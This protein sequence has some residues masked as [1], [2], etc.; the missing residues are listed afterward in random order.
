MS[1][2]YLAREVKFD[3]I[4]TMDN[5]LYGLLKEVFKDRTVV[6][7]TNQDELEGVYEHIIDLEEKPFEKEVI[8]CNTIDYGDIIDLELFSPA[9]SIYREGFSISSDSMVEYDV[10]KDVSGLN[11]CTITRPELL[12]KLNGSSEQVVTLCTTTSSRVVITNE[13][14]L[15]NDLYNTYSLSEESVA[16]TNGGLIYSHFIRDV[17]SLH[18]ANKR[19]YDRRVLGNNSN[20]VE[21]FVFINYRGDLSFI[22]RVNCTIFTA[23]NHDCSIYGVLNGSE[24]RPSTMTRDELLMELRSPSGT[25]SL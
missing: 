4:M 21:V 9:R 24:Y 5:S 10:F 25:H 15:M 20:Y 11:S 2:I 13:E 8:I 16:I 22:N 14:E 17:G 19:A 3:V 7:I 12:F 18:R 23:M 6:N 1:L